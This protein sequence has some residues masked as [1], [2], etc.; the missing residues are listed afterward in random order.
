MAGHQAGCK[1]DHVVRLYLDSLF[2]L[3]IYGIKRVCGQDMCPT[4]LALKVAYGVY[5]NP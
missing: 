3:T 1:A 2:D 4:Y 5:F